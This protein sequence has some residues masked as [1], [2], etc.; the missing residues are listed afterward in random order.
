V[1]YLS[2]DLLTATGTLKITS[3]RQMSR[4][5]PSGTVLPSISWNL[6]FRARVTWHSVSSAQSAL[7]RTGSTP[8]GSPLVLLLSFP[9]GPNPFPPPQPSSLHGC[10]HTSGYA[11]QRFCGDMFFRPRSIESC[12][13][14]GLFP[15]HETII[16]APPVSCIRFQAHIRPTKKV[17]VCSPNDDDP[18]SH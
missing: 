6:L 3:E 18:F 2:G 9:S 10:R 5:S 13:I 17:H 8:R 16:S 11:L 14:R 12:S 15:V 4:R 7:D 1:G